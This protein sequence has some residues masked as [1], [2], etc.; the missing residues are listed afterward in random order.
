VPDSSS[1]IQEKVNDLWF[2]ADRPNRRDEVA[3][4]ATV[5]LEKLPPGPTRSLGGY[6]D[7][8]LWPDCERFLELDRALQL[9]AQ[10]TTCK[11]A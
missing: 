4:S 3:S 8:E 1:V 5:V 9:R 2:E 7:Y 10:E 6:F 11:A